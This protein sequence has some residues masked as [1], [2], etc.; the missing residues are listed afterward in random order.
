MQKRAE[1]RPF[2][3]LLT[4]ACMRLAVTSSL[5]LSKGYNYYYYI[6]LLLLLLYTSNTRVCIQRSL[7]LFTPKLSTRSC[8][9]WCQNGTVGFKSGTCW[10]FGRCVTL[11]PSFQQDV[12]CNVVYGTF[13]VGYSVM[14]WCAGKILKCQSS[15]YKAINLMR[16]DWGWDNGSKIKLSVSR[17][18]NGLH[19]ARFCYCG[20]LRGFA[21]L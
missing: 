1:R 20:L 19:S 12:A 18:W 14:G 4:D 11:A 13:D 6:L 15:L 5:P 17:C 10:Q 3:H 2:Q 16:S 7:F 9:S 8:F 21:G